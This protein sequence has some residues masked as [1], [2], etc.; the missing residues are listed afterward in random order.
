MTFLPIVVRE[1][2]VAAR[3]VA[4]Y[5]LRVLVGGAA[6]V[7]AVMFLIFADQAPASVGGTVFAFL[8][9]G[10][11]AFCLFEGIRVTADTLAE[12][13]RE[14]TLGL[15]FLTDLSGFDVVLGKFAAAAVRSF[16]ALLAAFPVFALPLLVGGV[17]AGE[18]WRVLLA[19]AATMLV[20]LTAGMF[21]SSFT[22]SGLAAMGGTALLLAL[23]V[24]VPAAVGPGVAKHLTN[25]SGELVFLSGSIGGLWRAFEN[26]FQFAPEDYWLA[27]AG[28]AVTALLFLA[29]ASVLLIR[30]W[31]ETG[32]RVPDSWWQR[33]TRPRV[34]PANV[35][36]T[37]HLAEN[38]AL[39]LAERTLPGRR[40]IW[41]MVWGAAGVC[42]LVAAVGGSV[43]VGISI[44]I[45]MGVCFV[46][47]VW[48]AVLAPQSLNESRRTGALELLLVT[49]LSPRE[50]VRGQLETLMNYFM[51]PALMA[52]VGI[53]I[54]V[55]PVG[56]WADSTNALNSFGMLIPMWI[57]GMG[58][59][60]LDFY[61]ISY[62]GLWFGLTEPRPGQAAAR[63]LL[64]T[65]VAPWVTMIVP[66]FGCF[67]LLIWPVFWI[68]WASIRLDRRFREEV[69][70]P[71][72][73]RGS[74]TGWWPFGS[75]RRL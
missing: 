75:K 16:T 11:A 66:L 68:A 7:V 10:A 23:T 22:R 54:I 35:W 25:W 43:G 5:R 36:S 15:L 31:R 63:T 8:T 30:T 72:A 48:L 50:L 9:W 45:Q 12:E 28:A 3:Q 62:A 57:V 56:M 38:P 18:F 71:L 13:R 24:I 27:L 64:W 42:V 33:F 61:A 40:M 59:F 39:W 19:L 69:A 52:S 2:Q 34:N 1:L 29:A 41:W 67:G 6:F 26:H 14:G 37:G 65:M 73:A 44:A 32:E 51:G 46:L 4:T 58:L 70:T 53:S 17:T 47:K 74:G 20:S 55:L 21:V 60:V 49:G